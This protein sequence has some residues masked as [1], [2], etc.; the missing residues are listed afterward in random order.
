[1]LVLVAVL[2]A[3]PE[4]ARSVPRQRRYG[5]GLRGAGGWVGSAGGGRRREGEEGGAAPARGYS[6]CRLKHGWA[7]GCPKGGDGSCVQDW[8]C[9]CREVGATAGTDGC[10]KGGSWRLTAR[11]GSAGRR[12][13]LVALDVAACDRPFIPFLFSSSELF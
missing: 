6:C 10:P 4:A 12:G 7:G 13:L 5:D 8:G 9:P 11:L 3:R 1:M 2:G